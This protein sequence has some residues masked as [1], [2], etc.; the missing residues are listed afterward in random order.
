MHNLLVRKKAISAVKTKKY[1]GV[2]KKRKINFEINQK[3]FIED[4]VI[5]MDGP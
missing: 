5:E 3:D 1:C 2:S 4:V